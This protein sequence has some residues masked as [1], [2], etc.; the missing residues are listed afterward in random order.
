MVSSANTRGGG[1]KPPRGFKGVNKP[2]PQ[3]KT[4]PTPI[5]T[6]KTKIPYPKPLK[7]SSKTKF[8]VISTPPHYQK[9]CVRPCMVYLDTVLH[10]IPGYS[11]AWYTWIQ[12]CMVYLD[13]V[14]HGIP[15]FLG[16]CFFLR[17]VTFSF[18]PLSIIYN[19]LEEI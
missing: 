16:S 12:C 5:A 19:S 13:T 8:K 10:G 14:L 6:N 18:D 4:L 3:L 7:Q 2:L 15:C 11:V 17:N 1:L 9:S